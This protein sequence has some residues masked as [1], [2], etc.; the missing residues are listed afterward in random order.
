[1]KSRTEANKVNLVKEANVIM[2]ND[3][4]LNFFYNSWGS[5][6]ESV[7]YSVRTIKNDRPSVR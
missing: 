4:P 7:S 2:P 6:I 3:L 1:M 5:L